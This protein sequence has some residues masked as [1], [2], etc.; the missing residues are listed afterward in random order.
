MGS[1]GPLTGALLE[2][3]S[4]PTGRTARSR[5]R[6]VGELCLWSLA[7][8]AAVV[9]LL[10]VAARLRLVILPVL[11]AIILSTFLTPPVRW[12]EAHGWRSAPAALTVLLAALM[13]LGGVVA[14]LV[15][16]AVDE[17]SALDVSVT[18]SIDS[19]QAWMRDSLPFSAQ[20][21]SDA[22]DR[23]QQQL[24]SSLDALA[25]R[26]VVYSSTSVATCFRPILTHSTWRSLRRTPN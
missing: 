1:A 11:L 12:L 24:R 5:L 10:Y 22:I 26:V 3:A 14:V 7:I 6:R 19:V 4:R 18:G 23:V 8:G 13:V 2:P 16:L 25:S 15:P 9:A 17:F 21:T 20:E